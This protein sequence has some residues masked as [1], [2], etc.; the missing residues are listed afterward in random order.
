M[1]LFAMCTGYKGLHY[2]NF[3]T[4][5]GEFDADFIRQQPRGGG[6]AEPVSYV[7]APQLAR[8]CGLEYRES[9]SSTSRDWVNLIT[10]RSTEHSLAGTLHGMRGESRI[11]LVDDHV[12]EVPPARHM[13]VV[14]ND[15]RLGRI[16]AVATALAEA[17]INIADM[18]VGRSPGGATAL[19]VIATDQ[20]VPDQVMDRLTGAPGIL[21]VRR[22]E[23]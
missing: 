7:N 21:D 17:E 6:I 10:L 22:V 18:A 4:S 20:P 19:M 8:E 12:T 11:V 2:D 16:A 1:T 13:L 14:R 15:D 5:P 23:G 3:R 9:K